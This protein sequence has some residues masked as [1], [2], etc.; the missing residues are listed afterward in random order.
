MLKWLRSLLRSTRIDKPLPSPTALKWAEG[1]LVLQPDLN[2]LSRGLLESNR[3]DFQHNMLK[4]I[5]QGQN[6]LAPIQSPHSILDVGCGTG[7][8][9]SEVARQFPSARVVGLDRIPPRQ[10][11]SS[12]N[13]TFVEGNVLNSL[14]FENQVFDFV[15]MRLLYSAIPS[16]SWPIVLRELVRVTR[17]GG[18][19]EL[20]ETASIENRGPAADLLNTWIVESYRN[21]GLDMTM[22]SR[23]GI[24]LQSASIPH[25]VQREIAL[26]IGLHGG[27][28]GKMLEADVIG[29][30]QESKP[31]VV[32]QGLAS[33]QEYDAVVREWRLEAEH[34]SMLFPF[35]VA[36]G[37]RVL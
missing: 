21:R 5:L 22:G 10:G 24:M 13:Y 29:I 37:Q 23:I 28:L 26:P 32:S 1:R 14:A 11:E 35:Y 17:V 12:L 2:A 4:Y 31:L 15:H 16:L 30:F 18:W 25:V 33:G 8:W 27:Q 3:F 36:F 7:R 34:R 6:F 20:I 19:V 9:A